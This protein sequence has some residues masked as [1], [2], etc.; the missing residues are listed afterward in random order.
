MR[1]FKSKKFLNYILGA[2][3]RLYFALMA[4]IILIWY[5]KGLW[6]DPNKFIEYTEVAVHYIFAVGGLFWLIHFIYQ[7]LQKR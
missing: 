1:D 7:E 4:V 5:Y 3:A 2:L 6:Y